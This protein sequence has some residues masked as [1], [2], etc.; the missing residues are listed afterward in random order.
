M[1]YKLALVLVLGAFSLAPAPPHAPLVYMTSW[2][3]RNGSD[4]NSCGPSDPCRTFAAALANTFA[5]GVIACA[6]A[7]AFDAITIT[8]SITIDCTG[9]VAT[10]QQPTTVTAVTVNCGTGCDVRLRGLDIGGFG[11][12]VD[13]VDF[14]SGDRLVIENTRIHDRAGH[15]IVVRHMTN[16]E[17]GALVVSNS[18]VSDGSFGIETL[19]GNTVVSHSTLTGNNYALLAGNDG[20]IDAD[21]NVLAFN[22]TAV[23][24]GLTGGSADAQAI[25]R[26]SNNDIYSNLTGIGCGGGVV[27]SA[28]NNRKGSNT[29]G[30]ST[31]CSPT[32]AITQQ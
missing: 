15:G 24:A 2:V 16:G 4:S 14:V 3:A 30:T 10:I 25:I 32:V 28:G 12:Q 29:G 19:G 26:L 11:N 27:A 21:S 6:D 13:G 7:G 9:A 5:R 22:S 8:K 17:A 1:L 23:R 18:A 20:V 31:T